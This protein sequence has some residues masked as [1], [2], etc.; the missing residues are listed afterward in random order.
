VRTKGGMEKGRLKG[1]DSHLAL[2]SVD[3]VAAPPDVMQMADDML[4]APL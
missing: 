1:V 3:G 2:H 4:V